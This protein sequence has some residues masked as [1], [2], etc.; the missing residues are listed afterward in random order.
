MTEVAD[1]IRRGLNEA[2]A[3]GR[4]KAKGTKY[5]VRLPGATALKTRPWNV[6]ETLRTKADVAAY[7]NAAF[8][9]GDPRVVKHAL[10]RV[11]RTKYAMRMAPKSGLDATGLGKALSRNSGPSFT[12]AAKILR[13]L[14]FRLSVVV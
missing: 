5:R 4:G 13:A 6:V 11:L 3:D 14:G 7:L 2:V 8:E 10:S 1:S 12:T 9:D